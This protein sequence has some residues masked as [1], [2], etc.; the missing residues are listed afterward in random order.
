MSTPDQPTSAQSRTDWRGADLRGV[1][2]A[3]GDLEGADLRAADLRG[4]NFSHC[5]LR[6]ADLRGALMQGANCQHANLYAAKMQ[7]VEAQQADFRGADL[8]MANLGG[9]YLQGARL[10][11]PGAGLA[12]GAAPAGKGK[13]TDAG[14]LR[15]QLFA[16]APKQPPAAGAPKLRSEPQHHEERQRKH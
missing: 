2:F 10:P 5:N 12:N 1:S 7:G 11:E 6:Y 14:A 9:A 15:D 8:R 4:V 3:H 13:Q 16:P